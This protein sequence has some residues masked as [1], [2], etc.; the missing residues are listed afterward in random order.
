MSRPSAQPLTQI[1]ILAEPTLFVLRDRKFKVSMRH[2]EVLVLIAIGLFVLLS[3]QG[4]IFT[5]KAFNPQ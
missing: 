3:T 5:F 4:N 1:W 2:T